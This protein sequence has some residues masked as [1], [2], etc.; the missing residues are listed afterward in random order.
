M[1]TKFVKNAVGKM[2]PEKINGKKVIP[3]KGIGKY[4]PTGRKFAP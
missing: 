3:Y 2:I 1:K 4:K